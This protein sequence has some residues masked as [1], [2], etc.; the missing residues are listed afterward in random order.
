M[1]K[2]LVIPAVLLAAVLAFCLWNSSAVTTRTTQW[3]GELEKADRYAREEGW[4]D[5]ANL[6]RES[7]A[8]W[9]ECQTWLH[10]VA[11]HDVVDDAEAMYRRAVAFAESGEGSELRA[12]LADLRD[13]L[14]LLAKKEEPSIRNIL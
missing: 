8:G 3:R 5:A 1:K 11:D 2:G 14:Q 13:Q 4:E 10:C 12:E 7:Y 6:I 9:S